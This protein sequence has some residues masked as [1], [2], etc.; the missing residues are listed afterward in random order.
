MRIGIV[1]LL[2]ES[3]TFVTRPTTLARFEENLLTTD[4]D[5]FVRHFQS[6]HHEMGGFLEGL[7]DHEGVE[8][9]PLF[10]ARALPAG[11]I[12]AET[13]SRLV[14]RMLESVSAEHGRAPLDGILVAPHGATVSAEHPDADGHWL[15][16]LRRLVGDQVRIGGTLDLHANLS[17][18]MVRACDFLT[19]YRS[20]PHLDQRDRGIEAARI[21]INTLCGDGAGKRH[22]PVMRGSFP[23][24]AIPIDRQDTAAPWLKEVYDLAE[25]LRG[26]PSIISTSILLG[27]PY[28]DVAEMG[29]ATL[30]VADGDAEAAQAAADALAS[31]LLERRDQYRSQLIDVE[32]ALDQAAS[33]EAPVCLLDMGDNVGG[34]SPADSTFLLD[35]LLKRDCKS[36]VCLCDPDSVEAAARA[37]VG[38]TLTMPLG[39][40]SDDLHGPTVTTACR[41]IS[42]H[43]GRFEESQPRHGGMAKFDQGKTAIVESQHVTIMLTSRRMVPFSLQQL[44]SCQLDPESFDVLVAKGVHAPLA[45]YREACPSIIRVNTGGS[46]TADM[47][48]LEYHCRR[49]PLFPLE[50]L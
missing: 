15:G 16:E 13:W 4:A 41:V 12:D 18:A 36:F 24:L 25:Q 33:M 11:V 39:G 21:M 10:A 3:N 27:F 22:D 32:A 40:K 7:G 8:T 5:E 44:Y 47:S 49:Q 20:N 9:L 23:P 37:G 14:T 50:D 43:E 17:P 2:H 1:G 29:A 30:A 34:G 31:A 42:L 35:A 28:A 45:A 46:T 19:A 6:A 48:K 38:A 26:E